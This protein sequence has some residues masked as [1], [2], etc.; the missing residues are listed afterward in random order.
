LRV[1]EV[2]AVDLVREIDQ[3]VGVFSSIRFCGDAGGRHSEHAVVQAEFGYLRY[4][5]ENILA[6]LDAA[7]KEAIRAGKGSSRADRARDGDGLGADIDG[8]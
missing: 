4:V 1:K 7:R 3:A 6:R 8:G 5:A 2:R